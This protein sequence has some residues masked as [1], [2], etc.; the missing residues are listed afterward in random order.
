MAS[1]EEDFLT[2]SKF[3]RNSL[4]KDNDFSY[5]FRRPSYKLTS[6]RDINNR[7]SSDTRGQYYFF[8]LTSNSSTFWLID[9]PMFW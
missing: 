4:F 9:D 3:P 2:I 5:F 8:L 1:G 6:H 7:A